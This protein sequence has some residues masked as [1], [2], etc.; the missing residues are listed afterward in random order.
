MHAL[1]SRE[2]CG[3][4]GSILRIFSA[5]IK[6][7]KCVDHRIKLVPKGLFSSYLY[8]QLKVGDRL[9]FSG[10]LGELKVRLSDRSIV[11]IAGGSGTAPILSML[12]D[13]AEKRN[14]CPI[15]FLFGALRKGDLYFHE[16]LESLCQKI[17][18]LNTIT[19]GLGAFYLRFLYRGVALHKRPALF[20]FSDI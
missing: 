16:R 9:R 7:I 11:A 4:D 12:T 17:P 19:D 15:K 13:L 1:G 8:S 10:L 2:S 20:D 14:T 5:S 18:T 6:F 3:P